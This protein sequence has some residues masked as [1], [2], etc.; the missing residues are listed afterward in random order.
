MGRATPI[1]N[2]REEGDVC[3]ESGKQNNRNVYKKY[4]I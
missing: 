4:S 1:K 3:P 2:G